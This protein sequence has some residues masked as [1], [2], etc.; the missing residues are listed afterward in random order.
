MIGKK[1]VICFFVIFLLVNIFGFSKNKESQD[2][3]IEKS[4]NYIVFENGNDKDL[5]NNDDNRNNEEQESGLRK[6]VDLKNNLKNEESD[7][8][9][10]NVVNQEDKKIG[11]VLSGGTAKGLAHIGILKVLDEE[12]VPIEYV[13]GTSM[14]SIIGGMY[15]VGYTP[16]E[17]EEIAISMD[18]MSLFSDKIERKDKGAV[19]NSIEDKNS[20]VI[21]IKN[22]MPKLPSG[23]VG[24]KTASQRLNELFYGA[25]RVEDFRKFPRKFAAV[26]TDLESGEG[27][28]I[29]K[30]SIATAIRESLSI[31]SVFAPIRDGKRLYIDGGVVRN[32]PV[33]D[34]KVLG[35]DYTIGVNVGDGFT[36]RDESKMNLIDV[37]TDTTTIAGRQ[38]VERQIRML[39]L[40]MKPDLEKFESYDFSKVKEIIA[41]GEAVA[42]ANIDKIRKLSNPELYEKLEE[43][44]KEF[45]RT[46][47]DEYNITGIVIDGNKK[48][49]RTYFD[50]FFPKKL[51][52]LTRLDM[53]KI[54]N[55]IYQNGDFTTVY[56]E[57]K[58]NDLIIN[59]QEKPSDYLTL[60]GNINNEDLATV[61]VGF[62]GSKLLNNTNVRYS[63]KGTVAN[64]YGVKGKA[65]AELGK[66][67][68]AVIYGEFEYKRDII[69]NQKYKNGYFSFEN[70]KFKIGTGIG[71]E[72]YKNLLFSIGGGYQISD[73]EKHEN[74]AEN[75]RK[76]FP[77]YEAKLNYDT[78]DS[79]KFATRGVYFF[80]NYTLAN[81]KH[82][83]FNSLDAGGEINIPIGEKIT[84]TPGIAYLTS[85]G[86]DIPETYRPKMGGI[87]TADNSLEFAGMPSDKIRGG[88]IFV[89]SLK[90][91]Y[92]L[93]KLVYLDTTYSRANISG[94]SYSFGND[95]KESYRFGVGVKALTIPIYFGFAKVPGESWRYLL[96]FGYSPE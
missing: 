55:N 3:K 40:Y 51:G 94:K 49:T 70:R 74:N 83:K 16:E 89:G 23:V 21:P 50:K 47:K 30:G 64:E 44:R 81:S 77:Y 37:I 76:P 18:W 29:D 8:N 41:A 73:V 57:V 27:V 78:R 48:Y 36:K 6:D 26:A 15:S 52:T 35:A 7:I 32:L 17:I 67:S 75:V 38:E 63:V 24:G 79:L 20:T 10:K 14:G 58:D 84:I 53:E 68:K 45:R 13:T 5:K 96:N 31:P 39:D 82:A 43:K 60:S 85:Y 33:Q 12:K 92:N 80:S 93:S 88:S 86:K 28:M 42:R 87:R 54:V 66:N 65:T 91:Q 56:Y 62:Q 90:A 2:E 22:F 1:R 4:E 46:W 95:V 59:V 61:N 34:V 19:R 72:V 69:E 71:V 25:L 9:K 11:L